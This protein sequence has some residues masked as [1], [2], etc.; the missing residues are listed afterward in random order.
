MAGLFVLTASGASAAQS[1][2][3]AVNHAALPHSMERMST[4]LIGI[5]DGGTTGTI[6]VAGITGT[7]VWGFEPPLT[8]H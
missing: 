4:I 7:S 5:I 3:S 1:N 8:P 2:G 6:G